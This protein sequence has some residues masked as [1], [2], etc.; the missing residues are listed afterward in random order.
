MKKILLISSCL[1]GFLTACQDDLILCGVVK[2][3]AESKIDEIRIYSFD[4]TSNPI[5]TLLCGGSREASQELNIGNYKLSGY[6]YNGYLS[7]VTFQVRPGKTVVIEYNEN[8]IG[9]VISN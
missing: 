6:S 7:S 2:I 5:H 4:D 9:E 8:N 1:F 3:Y